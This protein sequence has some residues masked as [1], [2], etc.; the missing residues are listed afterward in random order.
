MHKM[1]KP[2]SSL[3]ALAFSGLTLLAAI[4]PVS[5]TMTSDVPM[6]EHLQ[7]NQLAVPEGN[8]A[9]PERYYIAITV[10]AGTSDL[11]NDLV[12]QCTLRHGYGNGVFRLCMKRG[13][14]G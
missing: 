8:A 12:R 7:G 11:C 10:G 9:Q 4:S 3:T 13:G 5:A 1:V 2:V 14:C 6:N